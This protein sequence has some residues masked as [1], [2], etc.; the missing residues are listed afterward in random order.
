MTILRGSLQFKV[1]YGVGVSS[2]RR[3]FVES[4]TTAARRRCW[5]R[6]GKNR[7]KGSGVNSPPASS[8][9]RVGPT[10][11][12][13]PLRGPRARPQDGQPSIAVCLSGPNQKRQ[14]LSRSR[15][16]RRSGSESPPAS[17]S[18]CCLN[19]DASSF[20]GTHPC[21]LLAPATVI[22]DA[23]AHWFLSSQWL[24]TRRFERYP[25]EAGPRN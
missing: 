9:P 17:S 12:Y 11:K 21:E 8:L 24:G 25:W 6:F 7:V 15:R 2:R 13:R 18:S 10:A 16:K 5:R 3:H 20:A 1:G 14:R 22:V 19:R 23:T 4:Q